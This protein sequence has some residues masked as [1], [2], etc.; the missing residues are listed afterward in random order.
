MSN[1]DRDGSGN[2]HLHRVYE[3]R[4]RSSKYFL[5]DQLRC[6]E[7]VQDFQTVKN[8]L[9]STSLFNVRRAFRFSMETVAVPIPV[10]NSNQQQRK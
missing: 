8:V 9:G 1:D 6:S 2:Q 4:Y 7:A 3:T 5:N 10:E